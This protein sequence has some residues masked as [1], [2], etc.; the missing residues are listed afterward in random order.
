MLLLFCLVLVAIVATVSISET[1]EL[2][3]NIQLCFHPIINNSCVPVQMIHILCPC[4][5]WIGLICAEGKQW[6]EQRSF[7][8]STLKTLG[9]VKVGATRERLEERIMEGVS[10]AVEVTNTLLS[11]KPTV[12][13]D[14]YHKL[15]DE[16]FL[17]QDKCVLLN[18]F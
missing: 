15:R 8:T 6:R 18:G 7:V 4:S 17:I 10:D 9:M 11:T 1:E 13:F 16:C 3:I 5:N 2:S 12:R 14:L